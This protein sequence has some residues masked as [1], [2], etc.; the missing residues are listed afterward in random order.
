MASA[1]SHYF[2]EFYVKSLQFN[3]TNGQGDLDLKNVL[4]KKKCFFNFPS[5]SNQLVQ[6][7]KLP[8]KKCE[9]NYRFFKEIVESCPPKASS[10]KLGKVDL[11]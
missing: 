4:D 9:P 3:L 8:Q 2:R 11:Q 5:S 10:N 6:N 1:W 7:T